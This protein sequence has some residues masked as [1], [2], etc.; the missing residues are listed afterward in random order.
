[1][2]LESFDN[3][4]ISMIDAEANIGVFKNELATKLG[5]SV[6]DIEDPFVKHEVVNGVVKQY[7]YVGLSDKVSMGKM[8]NLGFDYFDGGCIVFE[9]GDSI[10]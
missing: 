8:L 9:I 1:M 4:I 10:I 6:S 2:M 7:L 3:L 5:I